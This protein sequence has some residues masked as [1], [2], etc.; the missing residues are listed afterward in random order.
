ME[1]NNAAA[2]SAR[3]IRHMDEEMS[4]ADGHGDGNGALS[5]SPPTGVLIPRLWCVL[6]LCVPLV[7]MAYMSIAVL[8]WVPNLVGILREM[9]MR[10]PPPFVTQMLLATYGFW[11]MFPL[12]LAGA[13][14][15]IARR[16]R[17]GGVYVGGVFVGACLLCWLMQAVFAEGS[18]APILQMMDLLSEPYAP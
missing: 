18:F 15:D 6:F 7:Y 12:G 1:P 13:I 9:D 3:P 5:S 17:P 10:V 4:G 16:R 14:V 8:F 2:P 11:W